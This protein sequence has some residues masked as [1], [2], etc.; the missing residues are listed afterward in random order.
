M[1]GTH[2]HFITLVF[3]A[4]ETGLFTFQ[5]VIYV[6]KARDDQRKRLLILLALMMLYNITGGLFPDPSFRITI[7]NQMMLTYGSGLSV[8]LF[9]PYYFTKAYELSS[10]RWHL[11]SRIP[12]IVCLPSLVFF[13]VVFIVKGSLVID[14]DYGMITPMMSLMSLLWIR[15][16]VFSNTRDLSENPS[17]YLD[18]TAVYGF[19]GPWISFAIFSLVENNQMLEV[20]CSNSGIIGV[21]IICIRNSIRNAAR[22]HHIRSI[23][24]DPEWNPNFR[25]ACQSYKLTK[26]EIEIALLVRQGLSYRDISEKLFIS[27]KT[28]ENHLQHIY[29]KTSVNNKVAMLN[30]LSIAV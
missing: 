24:D 2:I 20:L 26:R 9:F 12:I 1:F 21:T 7:F 22:V 27:G 10:I 17:K 29:E 30:K 18:V 19:I 13:S 4:M 6:F 28:V 15:F 8:T 14:L 25:Q 5:L 16:K 11:S 23:T 3:I